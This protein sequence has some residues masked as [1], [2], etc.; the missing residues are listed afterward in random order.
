[1]YDVKPPV[2]RTRQLGRRQDFEWRATGRA[3]SLPTPNQ[4]SAPQ[5]VG[6]DSSN[7]SLADTA[8]QSKAEAPGFVRE[9][10]VAA[11]DRTHLHK[12]RH[13]RAASLLANQAAPNLFG[14]TCDWEANALYGTHGFLEFASKARPSQPAGLFLLRTAH[15]EAEA[16]CR[17]IAAFC[18]AS[19]SSLNQTE[20]LHSGSSLVGLG[21]FPWPIL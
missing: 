20:A 6:G 1:M 2:R 4:A 12:V 13:A 16:D 15:A 18:H 14:I 5:A 10:G 19:T 3:V 9:D 17:S 11:H 21:N 7:F 8:P